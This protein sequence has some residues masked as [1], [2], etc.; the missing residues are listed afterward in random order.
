M[1]Q[2]GRQYLW[3]GQGGP[4]P[5]SLAKAMEIDLLAISANSAATSHDDSEDS[6][7][8]VLQVAARWA[9]NC[10]QIQDRA[11]LRKLQSEIARVFMSHPALPQLER[12]PMVVAAA[13]RVQSLLVFLNSFEHAIPTETR[14]LKS[15]GDPM[16]DS[17]ATIQ[18][19]EAQRAGGASPAG[20]LIIMVGGVEMIR[21]EPNGEIFVRGKLAD[22][23]PDVVNGLRSLLDQSKATH[24]ASETILSCGITKT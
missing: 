21:L 1:P 18:T 16:T 8:Y 9:T 22:T 19:I 23:D 20:N 6:I 10:F 12:A 3:S 13:S 11:P 7:R 24:H 5:E 2:T 17:E 4:T 15:Y 14:N